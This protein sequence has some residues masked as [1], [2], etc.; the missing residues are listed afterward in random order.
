LADYHLAAYPMYAKQARVDLE[1]YQ[2][3]SRWLQ[4]MY[5][6]DEWHIATT[7]GRISH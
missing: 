1:P 7:C 4:H 5:S 3:L 6:L 2:N